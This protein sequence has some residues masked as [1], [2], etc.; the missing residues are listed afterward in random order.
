MRRALV[1]SL[2]LGMAAVAAGSARAQDVDVDSIPVKKSIADRLTPEQLHARKLAIA[3]AMKPRELEN[4]GIPRGPTLQLAVQSIADAAR[5]GMNKADLR[6]RVKQLVA[7][8]AAHGDDAHF[9]QLAAALMDARA[10]PPA[11]AAFVARAAPAPWK[12]WGAD[13]EPES[14]QQMRNACDLPEIGRAHV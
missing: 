12:Q 1:A 5:A 13:L 8:P 11:S 7:D 3:Q 14:I 6:A 2:L 4:L 10:Q 9:G